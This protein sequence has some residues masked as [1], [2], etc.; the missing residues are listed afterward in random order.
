MNNMPDSPDTTEA[1]FQREA[2]RQRDAVVVLHRK[3]YTAFAEEAIR[4]LDHLADVDPRDVEPAFLLSMHTHLGNAM[5]LAMNS[6]KSDELK[7]IVGAAFALN[8][9]LTMFTAT[10]RTYL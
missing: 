9:M 7:A 2:A 3:A 5:S 10:G 6:R 8:H 4:H 1:I